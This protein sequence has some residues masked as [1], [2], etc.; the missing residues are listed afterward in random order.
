MVRV[1]TEFADEGAIAEQSRAEY[2][3]KA[4][5]P[6]Y[7]VAVIQEVA[8]GTFTAKSTGVT[9]LKWTPTLDVLEKGETIRV[10][11][12]DIPVG[13]VNSR[14]EL[15]KPA[16]S[17]S[18]LWSMAQWFLSAQ[19]I[20]NIADASPAAMIGRVVRIRLDT[21]GYI[22]GEASYSPAA[23]RELVGDFGDV[24]T[25]DGLRDAVAAFNNA[26]GYG[27]NA[28]LKLTN[29]IIGFYAIKPDAAVEDGYFLADDQSVWLDEETY[30][31]SAARIAA[32]NDEA[33]N[34][35]EG[36]W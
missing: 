28:G 35:A 3:Y 34:T 5:A 29:E 30:L 10:G 1:V 12:K 17:K 22:K 2:V 23:L 18:L 21:G 16:N 33:D 19:R 26:N 9:Y 20:R 8:E 6:G 31:L 14:G 4:L 25:F 36:S 13:A 32:A 11:R 27:E 15:Y 7:Y 24:N